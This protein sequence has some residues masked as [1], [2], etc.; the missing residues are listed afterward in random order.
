[1]QIDV[2]QATLKYREL[3]LCQFYPDSKAPDESNSHSKELQQTGK[4][5]GKEF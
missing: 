5:K 3:S 1:M 4:T 2:R